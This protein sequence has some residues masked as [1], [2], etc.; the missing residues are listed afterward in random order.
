MIIGGETPYVTV[1]K[2]GGVNGI[3]HVWLDRI[4]KGELTGWFRVR[5]WA[6]NQDFEVRLSNEEKANDFYNEEL[7]KL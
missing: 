1:L 3:T 2:C 7:A 4:E 5:V 6:G